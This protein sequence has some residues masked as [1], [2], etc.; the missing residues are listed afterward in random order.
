MKK[1]LLSLCLASI[2]ILSACGNSSTSSAA[3][4]ESNEQVSKSKTESV[5]KEMVE[6]TKPTVAKDA[7]KIEDLSWEI[8]TQINDYGERE[9]VA[10]YTNN[11]P[12]PI[13]EFDL[14]MVQKA[15]VTDEDRAVLSDL[16]DK[17]DYTDEDLQ[18]LYMQ[19][20]IEYYTNPGETSKGRYISLDIYAMRV[21]TSIEQT[22]LMEPDIATITYIGADN[23][24]HVEYYDFVGKSY[25]LSNNSVTKLYQAPTSKLADSFVDIDTPLLV[26]STD[27]SDSYWAKCYRID[28]DGFA[29][30]V[31]AW[32]AGGYSNVTWDG[33]SDFGATND[34][35]VEVYL[36][37]FADSDTMVIELTGPA[38]TTET[39]D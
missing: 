31:E 17:Y 30:C 22:E 33:T 24:V 15:D 20:F 16:K 6:E 2:L 23:A 5:S 34:S 18:K 39:S 9:I 32:K 10:N 29:K 37:W 38:D 27:D 4:A 36:N 3:S 28:S 25:S 35:G 14:K 1:E 19:A 21:P 11:S 13:V 26:A 12:Y 8:T 7:I